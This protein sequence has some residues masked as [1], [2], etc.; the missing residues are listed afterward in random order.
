MHSTWNIVRN[1]FQTVGKICAQ[2]VVKHLQK[3]VGGC[4]HFVHKMFSKH[5]NLLPIHIIYTY[6]GNT[7]PSSPTYFYTLYFSILP[8]CRQCLS[9]L[10]THLITMTTIYI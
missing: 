3:F 10:S 1:T 2:S 7:T 6:C 8:L 5:T 4:T 9:P